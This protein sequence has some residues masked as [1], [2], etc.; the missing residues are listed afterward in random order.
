MLSLSLLPQ[1]PLLLMQSQHKGKRTALGEYIHIWMTKWN[2]KHTHSAGS[3]WH[4]YTVTAFAMCV[5]PSASSSNYQCSILKPTCL[6]SCRI[7]TDSETPSL[8]W[9][10]PFTSLVP[11]I[12]K[13]KTK[14]GSTEPQMNFIIFF[15][16]I[17]QYYCCCSQRPSAEHFQAFH[18]AAKITT[19]RES[20]HFFWYNHKYDL[21]MEEKIIVCK[22]EKFC[23]LWKS[24]FFNR[25]DN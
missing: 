17:L 1:P 14:L 20:K 6:F 21:K 4:V 15:Y 23:A 16:I 2:Y 11:A 8:Q 22:L 3:V 5:E 18:T 19:T 9:S 12:H 13:T 25:F 10:L 7:Y 24:D